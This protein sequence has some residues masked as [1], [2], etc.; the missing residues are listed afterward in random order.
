MRK[1][2]VIGAVALLVLAAAVP[3]TSASTTPITKHVDGTIVVSENANRTWLARFEVRTTSDVVQFGYLELYGIGGE[4]A[5]QIHEFTVY[6]VDYYKTASRAQ[7]ATLRMQECLIVPSRPACF[8]SPYEVSD[9]SAVGQNDTFM[10]Q[11]GWTVQ[12]GNISI[13]ST[14]GQNGR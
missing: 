4:V 2:I 1:L 10:G 9:G 11:I 8:D 5:G 12:S 6:H 7:G 13:Y 14:G 3:L